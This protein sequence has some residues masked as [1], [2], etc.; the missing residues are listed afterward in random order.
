MRLVLGLAL[1]YCVVSASSAS[2][3]EA[4]GLPYDVARFLAAL[5]DDAESLIVLR[6]PFRATRFSPTAAGS[7]DRQR[8]RVNELE[9]AKPSS[10]F[11]PPAPTADSPAA[12]VN[13]IERINP[14]LPFIEDWVT[15]PL[16]CIARGE[17][18]R[19]HIAERGITAAMQGAC[20]IRVDKLLTQVVDSQKFYY[21][22]I[23]KPLSE[24]AFAMLRDSATGTR[25]SAT[26]P[27]LEIPVDPKWCDVK[28][29][30]VTLIDSRR[31]LIA[32]DSKHDLGSRAGLF[33]EG[34]T[35]PVQLPRAFAAA[36]VPLAAIPTNAPCWAL[37]VYQDG[38]G[39]SDD[40]TNPR[41]AERVLRQQDPGARCL[42]FS[43][44]SV[45]EVD[46]EWCYVS[47]TPNAGKL[48]ERAELVE[49]ERGLR[50]KNVGRGIYRGRIGVEAEVISMELLMLL[51]QIPPVD[52]ILHSPL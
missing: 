2:G 49:F 4:P 18:Y 8:N 17:F 6:Y 22:E 29:L 16:A 46:A 20:R 1:V 40:W 47:T 7:W 30:H 13:H 42:V 50:M 43:V 25:G 27:T 36:R 11:P 31:L 39:D 28:T 44:P 37:R 5:P 51:G 10:T 14:V 9:R 34:A 41:S 12:A 33:R 35:A 38:R 21:L 3:A 23:E 45:G 26:Q 19:K 32:E 48:F 52:W 24:D 15:H